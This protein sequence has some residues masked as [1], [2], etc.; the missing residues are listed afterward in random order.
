MADKI[1]EQVEQA[2]GLFKHNGNTRY[3]QVSLNQLFHD[4]MEHVATRHGTSFAGAL[5]VCASLPDHPITVE[6]QKQ[7]RK[8]WKER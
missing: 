5:Q 1:E 2:V 3:R 4:V 6:F 7:L 8:A